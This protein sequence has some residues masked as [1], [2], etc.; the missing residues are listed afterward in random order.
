MGCIVVRSNPL[1]PRECDT[2]EFDGV[3]I[4]FIL[5]KYPGGFP[6][7]TI[8]LLN[9]KRLDVEYMDAD[10]GEDDCVELLFSPGWEAVG[11]ALITALVGTAVSYATSW[12]LG[13]PDSPDQT[14]QQTPS[15]TYS[16]NVPTNTPRLN[17]AM[18]VV[19]GSPL[20]V[21]DI[22]SQPYSF[23]LDNEQYVCMLLGIGRGVHSIDSIQIADTP[24][25][26]LPAGVFTWWNYPVNNHS[27]TFGKIQEE[28]GIFEDVDTSPEVSN[29]ELADTDTVGPF[30]CNG[31]GTTTQ[32]IGFDFVMPAGIHGANEGN[33]IPYQLDLTAELWG[34]DDDGVETGYYRFVIASYVGQNSTPQRHTLWVDVPA[35]RYKAGAHRNTLPVPIVGYESRTIWSGL[36]A[37]L[38]EPTQPDLNLYTFDSSTETDLSNWTTS[39]PGTWGLVASTDCGATLTPHTTNP[40]FIAS[41]FVPGDPSYKAIYRGW[42][43]T[44]YAG[45]IDIGNVRCIAQSFI[46]TETAD[47][48]VPVMKISFR[49]ENQSL[50][51][52]YQDTYEFTCSW[53]TQGSEVDQLVPS[54]TRR[55]EMVLESSYGGV[56][57]NNGS[58]FDDITINLS[59]LIEGNPRSV[60]EDMHIIP[61]QV[62]ATNGVAGDAINRIGI[63]VTRVDDFSEPVYNPSYIAQDIYQNI[64]YGGARPDTEV[65]ITGFAMLAG[66]VTGTSGFNGVF[67]SQ[68]TVWEAMQRVLRL[69]DAAP[70][71]YGGKVTPVQDVF[72]AFVS[73]AFTTDNIVDGSAR[74][75]RNFETSAEY[76]GFEVEYN[77]PISFMPKYVRYPVDCVFP[78][79]ATFFG[80]TDVEVAEHQAKFLW[81]K[82]KW[83]RK[84]VTF[85]TEAIGNLPLVGDLVS[86]THPDVTGWTATE[87]YIV[88]TVTPSGQ[89]A[90]TIEGIRDADIYEA[91]PGEV[92]DVR[93][94]QAMVQS[95]FAPGMRTTQMMVQAATRARLHI[96][97]MMVQIVSYTGP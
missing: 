75:S 8:I 25:D 20:V 32:R 88:A 89:F 62:K 73:F 60:Y 22:I 45:S 47:P 41:D 52:E 6:A 27:N 77:D 33:L 57:T 19:Y 83:R 44:G 97:Q 3:L 40:T 13:S 10:I 93:T 4:D 36:K 43:V 74:V 66:D 79:R 46:T 42:D 71:V 69:V 70:T 7:P 2:F 16:L 86:V 95:V 37:I 58:Y 94:S 11:I 28:T 87:N 76:D 59:G 91:I 68:T 85:D 84:F 15:P 55:I 92:P 5:D 61:V 17:E 49:D 30:V 35:G 26:V 54:G 9:G 78:E 21:P 64:V 67:D 63:H 1:N 38:R 82:K 81:L 24:I 39:G 53:G 34:I 48:D 90:A 96:S 12:L 50:L 29:Q 51:A 31:V 72:R 80:C 23:H 65:D 56:G 14:A 18:P